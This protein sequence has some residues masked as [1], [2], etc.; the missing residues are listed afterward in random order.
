MSNSA[1]LADAPGALHPL[2][3]E[4]DELKARLA[5]AEETLHAI[6]QGEVDAVLVKGEAGAQVYTLLNADRPYRNIVERMQE[7]ALTLTPDGTILYANQ[8]LA[9]F[10]GLALPS[11]VGQKFAQ[12]VAADDRTSLNALLAESS[13]TAGKA[14]LALCAADG[15]AVPVYLSLVDLADEGQKIISGIVTDLRWHKQRM[16]ELG[17]ANA[18]LIA[19]MVERDAVEEKLRQA[20]KMEAVGQLTA[21]IAHDFNNLLLVIAGN[22]ELFHARTSDKWLKRRVEAGQR[23]VERGSRLTH[24]LLAFARRQTL[25]PH[26][27]SVNALLRELGPLLHSAL[28][29][30]IRLA[31]V[32]GEELPPCLVDSAE[33]Q[34][35]IL[36]LAANA[37][38]AMP[39]GGSLTI[40]TEEV[41]L[42]GQPESNAESIRGG[43]YVSIVVTD[44]G[45]GMSPEIRAR[46][47]DPFF[48]TKE[49]G[50]GTG[51][52]LSRI[53]GFMCQSGGQVTIESG[54]GVGTSVRLFF[55]RL[56]RSALVS[57]PVTASAPP[58][59][60]PLARRVLVVEDD[61]DVRELMV[62]LLE[63]FGYD[64]FAAESGPGALTL[65]DGGLAVDLVVS[66][67]L[68][69]DGLSGFQLA[70]E[71][72]RRSPRLPIVLTSGMT[73]PAY[74]AADAMLDLP[75]LRK[76]Y[77]CEALQQA[78]EAVLDAASRDGSPG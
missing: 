78:I 29:G 26:S 18:K 23:A 45:C 8:R 40:T 67:V 13:G 36:N 22:L 46:A 5:E 54:V 25:L 1:S 11:I 63:G 7:G 47:C 56:E 62:E 16:R 3:G 71:I 50:K 37:K 31:F 48:T 70:R 15:A 30:G 6:R 49:M 39:D 4:I 43:G 27:I 10:L 76:P 38:D 69:P 34:A 74:T 51:L 61:P 66:D 35:A 64:V 68:M 33:L 53:Y 41:E 9:S 75:I 44:S 2:P 57:Q 65:L 17:D 24:Q 19:T 72:R 59:R 20:E 55:P 73:D 77:R 21:G 58:R 12:F 28:G 60:S 32:L 14:E 42:V 52:G